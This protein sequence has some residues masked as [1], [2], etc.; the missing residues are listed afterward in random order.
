MHGSRWG[1]SG[2]GRCRA[3]CVAGAALSWIWGCASTHPE[4]TV[5]AESD[6]ALA[7]RAATD[8]LRAY[9]FKIERSDP[10]AGVITTRPKSSVGF[11]TPWDPDQTTLEQEARESVNREERVVR[12]TFEPRSA[13]ASG[14]A[15]PGAAGGR[16]GEGGG[17][18]GGSGT[19]YVARVHVVQNRLNRSGFR[20]DTTA[21]NLSGYTL[22]PALVARDMYGFKVPRREDPDLAARLAERIGARIEEVRAERAVVPVPPGAN[23]R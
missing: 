9:N 3:A 1:A 10:V 22:D 20:P 4:M 6:Y 17:G 8:V 11:F 18:A 21:I 15:T 7:F 19:G 23:A 2:I 16:E 12:V 13:V 14:G 5:V